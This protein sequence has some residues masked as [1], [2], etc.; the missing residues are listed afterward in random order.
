L[1]FEAE[2]SVEAERDFALIFDV[3]VDHYTRF[4][5]APV[6]AFDRAIEHIRG[7]LSD[8]R[9]LAKTPDLEALHDDILPTCGTRR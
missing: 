6:D 4:G 3:L 2:F 1:A 9:R 8:V 5:E 7:R